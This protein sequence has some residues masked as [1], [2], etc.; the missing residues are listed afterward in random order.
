MAPRPHTL[1]ASPGAPVSSVLVTPGQ[2]RPRGE[3]DTPGPPRGQATGRRWS[4]LCPRT[5]CPSR[6]GLGEP[7]SS[8][9]CQTWAR[10]CFSWSRQP[11]GVPARRQAGSCPDAPPLHPP[12]NRSPINL[13]V[14]PKAVGISHACS[15]NPL[16]VRITGRTELC[17]QDPDPQV[18]SPWGSGG[19]QRRDPE[20]QE[21]RGGARALSGGSQIG[22]L[23]E[24]TLK[25]GF[26]GC[27]GVGCILISAIKRCIPCSRY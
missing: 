24:G 19:A 20:L 8:G 11:A 4:F 25:L 13:C 9:F 12:T 6:Q 21:A 2:A 18:C 10:P 5:R 7:H 3:R 17:S 16:S 1:G 27:I 14:A 26:E 15:F 22:F 23:E